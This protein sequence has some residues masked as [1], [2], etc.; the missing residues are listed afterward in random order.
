MNSIE[1]TYG[2]RVR[3]RLYSETLK[4]FHDISEPIGY[5]SDE[6]E[7]S[8]DKKYFGIV[9]KTSDDLKFYQGTTDRVRNTDGGYDFIL[10]VD[11]LGVNEVIYIIKEVRDN[12]T[13]VYKESYRTELDLTTLVKESDVGGRKF[14]SLKAFSGGLDALIKSRKKEDV[15]L[16][17]TETID[18][19]V[20]DE[21][22]TQ[23]IQL[24]GRKIFKQSK[25]KRTIGSLDLIYGDYNFIESEL[26][27]S[28][29]DSF[30]IVQNT[31]ATRLA[32]G[33]VGDMF[34]AIAK[35]DLTAN[36]EIDIYMGIGETDLSGQLLLILTKYGG[37][38]SYTYISEDI[39]MYIP[40]ND[41]D[42]INKKINKQINVLKDES[43]SISLLPTT[44]QNISVSIGK[45]DLSMSELSYYPP[46]QCRGYLMNNVFSH[47][48]EVITNKKEVLKSSFFGQGGIGELMA[49][50]DGGLVRQIP[51]WRLKTSLEDAISSFVATWNLSVGIENIGRKQKFV[52]EQKKYFFDDR[53]V[54]SLPNKVY[55]I[56]RTRAKEYIYSGAVFGYKGNGSYEN[57]QGL[58]KTNGITNRNTVINRLENIYKQESVY[59]TDDYE[60]EIPRRMPYSKYPTEDTKYD[61]KV[62]ILDCKPYNSEIIKQRESSKEIEEERSE[63]DDF[64]T[65]PTGVIDAE[66]LTNGRWT[67]LAMALRHGYWLRSGLTRYK[68]TDFSFSSSNCNVGLTGVLKQG[69]NFPYLKGKEYSE[70]SNILVSD[71]EREIFYPEWIEFKH[72]VT[73]DMLKTLE[74]Y[75]LINGERKQNFYGLIEFINED[76]EKEKGYL[77]NLKPNGDG[78]WKLLR[79]KKLKNGK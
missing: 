30:Q 2:D 78:Q 65:I 27:Y 21:I 14:L 19:L 34:Y 45:F 42:I 79:Y 26:E 57:I 6:V 74:G 46:T 4:E 63:Y 48:L 17:R 40:I 66:G 59:G 75:T 54:L 31:N 43:F 58:D 24:K 32:N 47:L 69:A 73:D 9:R 28:S 33:A 60:R 23:L 18:G 16:L 50:T 70:N 53:V 62:M 77:F 64:E 67:P 61:D 20:I 55:N 3:Y 36:L 29:D 76:N 10:K 52:I 1:P 39:L 49:I 51:N 25:Q 22:P 41:G 12:E 72:F 5:D 15:E 11:D 71:L 35:N 68:N 13:N 7:L 56:K 37:G 44:A 8:R 38:D